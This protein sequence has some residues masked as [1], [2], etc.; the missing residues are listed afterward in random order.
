QYREDV[1]NLQAGAGDGIGWCQQTRGGR[2]RA[3]TA[4]TYLR[5]AMKRANLQVITKALVRRILF[6]GRRAVAVEF[7]RGGAVQR[8]DA[9]CEIIL[10]AGAIGSPHILQLSGVGSPQLLQPGGIPVPPALPG[11]GPHP[12]HHYL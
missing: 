7:E 8:V 10:S 2:R 11:L 12:P 4:R 6:D 3:S 9:D 5:P 1:N